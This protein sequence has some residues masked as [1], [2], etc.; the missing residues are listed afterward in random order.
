MENDRVQASLDQM[1]AMVELEREM[2]FIGELY[3]SVA[4]AADADEDEKENDGGNKK[5]TAREAAL[6]KTLA[7]KKNIL[8]EEERKLDQMRI[9][10]QKL[11]LAVDPDKLGDEMRGRCFVM[12]MK[13][14]QTAK[15][16][17][18]TPA[19]ASQSQ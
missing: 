9:M 18:E 11:I 19:T 3:P 10:L 7:G 6:A 4:A 17:Q 5:M 14:G 16:W 1:E 8:T 2:S 13:C 15:Q 12:A